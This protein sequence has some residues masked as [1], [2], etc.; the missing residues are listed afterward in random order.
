MREVSPKSKSEAEAEPQRSSMKR[1]SER[2]GLSH[3]RDEIEFGD[4][5]DEDE[6][7]DEPSLLA[8]VNGCQTASA[9]EGGREEQV[10]IDLLCC[11]GCRLGWPWE[12]GACRSIFFFF[13]GTA[14]TNE[15]REG[16]ICVVYFS[17]PRQ[18]ITVFPWFCSKP[19]VK[20][21]G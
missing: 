3:G 2:D 7:E 8:R 1:P 13:F 6:V 12:A 4:E 17:G 21:V 20:I 14:E 15:R 19:G 11:S 16:P 18:M 9:A 5:K 10:S